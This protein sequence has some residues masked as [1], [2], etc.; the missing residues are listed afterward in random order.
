MSEE[1]KAKIME[2]VTSAK[3][4][5]K[6]GDLAKKISAEM[7]VGKSDVKKA[8]KELVGEDKLVFTYYGSSYIELPGAGGP[9]EE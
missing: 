5:Q 3:K 4:K 8:I 6:P 9:A 7:G 2:A 1:I